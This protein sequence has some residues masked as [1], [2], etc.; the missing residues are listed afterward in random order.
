MHKYQQCLLIVLIPAAL[1]ACAGPALMMA[2]AVAI[3]KSNH[4]QTKVAEA[5]LKMEAT[6]LDALVSASTAEQYFELGRQYQQKQ[7]PMAEVAFRKALQLDANH[8]ESMVNLATVLSTKNQF[9]EAISLFER[10]V[11]LA[12]TAR[13]YSNLGYAYYLSQ[14]YTQAEAVLQQA[15]AIDPGYQQA[16]NNL[17]LVRMNQAS[18]LATSEQS[19]Q[20]VVINQRPAAEAP[21]QAAHLSTKPVTSALM[22]TSTEQPSVKPL[23]VVAPATQVIAR[24]AQHDVYDLSF[25]SATVPVAP[26]PAPLP[27]TVQLA[28]ASGGVSLTTPRKLPAQLNYAALPPMLLSRAPYV[29]EV[30]NANGTKRIAKAVADRMA[31]VGV[32]NTQT[33][34]S[35]RFNIAQSNIQYH[36]KYKQDAAKLN[37]L[38][39]NKLPL[40][41]NTA[42]P[43]QVGL[44]IVLAKD[45]S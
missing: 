23:E 13:N 17:E 11:A 3:Y 38:F 28:V 24:N 31:E 29:I 14:Q 27:N 8:V 21:A 19:T 15:T 16:K 39:V 12:P 42:L 5:P 2:G 32:T 36:P 20:T 33:R 43:E 40:Y 26:M 18:A 37:Q 41:P 30:V 25:P 22:P 10:V 45:F 1:S 4:A 6:G 7:S 34:D 44:K 35:K 9:S